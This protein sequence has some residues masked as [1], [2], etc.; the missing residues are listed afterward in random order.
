MLVSAAESPNYQFTIAALAGRRRL[1][2]DDIAMLESIADGREAH[3]CLA[4]HS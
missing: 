2:S 4:G 3:R 1:L